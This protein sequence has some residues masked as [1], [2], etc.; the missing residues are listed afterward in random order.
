MVCL[1]SGCAPMIEAIRE[2]A[3]Q[4]PYTSHDPM[5]ATLRHSQMTADSSRAAM[6]G[7]ARE[8][9]SYIASVTRML[10]P[11]VLLTRA[12]TPYLG[13]PWRHFPVEGRG[14][15][16][17]MALMLYVASPQEQE[18]LHLQRHV[19]NGPKGGS[20]SAVHPGS[21]LLSAGSVGWGFMVHDSCMPLN[22]CCP[23]ERYAPRNPPSRATVAPRPATCAERSLEALPRSRS[24]CAIRAC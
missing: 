17:A 22:L 11:I 14:G 12:P 8:G 23:R 1:A 21:L 16:S 6:G 7:G 15:E 18:N 20:R 2:P 3:I 4:M 19:G 9:F 10:G 13:C 24:Y 5:F